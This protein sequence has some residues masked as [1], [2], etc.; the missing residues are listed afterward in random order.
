MTHPR[1]RWFAFSLRT[2]L[3]VMTLLCFCLADTISVMRARQAALT[4]LTGQHGFYE[5]DS[6]VGYFTICGRGA[7]L[8]WN[9][10]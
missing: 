10:A 1:R 5:M 9:V 8:R 4:T 3:G 2:M 6:I 7:N